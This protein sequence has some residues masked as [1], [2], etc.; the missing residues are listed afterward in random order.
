[1]DVAWANPVGKAARLSGLTIIQV[2]KKRELWNTNFV[3]RLCNGQEHSFRCLP[4]AM[5]VANLEGGIS[6]SYSAFYYDNG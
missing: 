1:M 2:S 6:F 4:L 5:A 3:V